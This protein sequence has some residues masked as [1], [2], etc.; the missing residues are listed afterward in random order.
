MKLYVIAGESSGDL[1]AAS[2]IRELRYLIPDIKVR[3]MGGKKLM[4][5]GIELSQDYAGLNFMG[6]IEVLKNLPTILRLMKHIKT[7]ILR[8]Q[9]DAILLVDYPGFNLRMA[10]FCKNNGIRVFY[11]ISP[12]LWAWKENRVKKI[13]KYVD[14]ML[15]ILPFEEAFYAR[16]GIRVH[17]VGHPL[18]DAIQHF[19]V[20]EKS[21]LHFDKPVIALL[22]GS[23]KGEVS[24]MLPVMLQAANAF[25]HHYE[26]VVAGAPSLPLSFYHSFLQ[27]FPHVKLLENQTYALLNI[28][29]A[30][31]VTSGTATL[32]T[33][34][35]NVPQV[36]C[37][38]GSRISY[39]IAK[40]LIKVNYISLVNL[41][42]DK[43][44]VK[45]LIQHEFTVGA[46]QLELEH[47][48]GKGRESMLRDYESLRQV[49]G[50]SGASIH[51]AE[52]IASRL[53]S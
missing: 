30:A 25:K 9:P 12:Q 35:F 16:H 31:L 22:P 49:L 51:A 43:P 42:L 1:H 23:R 7:D 29:Y 10:E 39:E 44:V 48:L 13:K 50:N 18:L 17:Y 52:T 40:R 24:A 33:A 45:E 27:D 28:A 21:V 4:A 37:Y 15:V 3:G 41:I 32:E 34:L 11:Y 14:E 46:V 8:W 2:L 20:S 5:E 6:F 36:V 47:V 26:I 38:K 19:K 53:R